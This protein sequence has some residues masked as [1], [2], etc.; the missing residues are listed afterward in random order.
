MGGGALPLVK[1][2][3]LCL[4]Y[5]FLPMLCGSN[6]AV[7]G[8]MNCNTRGEILRLLQVNQQ[9][10]LAT[11]PCL[12]IKNFSAGSQDDQIPL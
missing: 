11:R 9:Q 3:G 5:A 6:E 7:R 2:S 10:R 4:R 12:S 1:S 8:S